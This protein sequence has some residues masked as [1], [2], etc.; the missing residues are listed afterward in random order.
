ME[1]INFRVTDE[2]L[3]TKGQRFCNYLIDVIIQYAIVFV[4]AAVIGLLAYWT[5]SDGILIWMQSMNGWEEYLVGILIAIVYYNIMEILFS[6]SVGKYITNTVV[7]LD[8]GTKPDAAIIIKRTFCRF[9]PFNPLSFLGDRGW[10]DSISDTHVVK[11]A[12]LEHS[13]DL[14]FSF[15]EIGKSDEEF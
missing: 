11:K 6:R 3:A 14:F 10:H 4:L 8:D 9:I 13:R 15:D 7:V 1:N 2:I 12:A 5:N